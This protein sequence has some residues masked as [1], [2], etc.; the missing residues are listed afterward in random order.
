MTRLF[1][2]RSAASLVLSLTVVSASVAVA[3]GIEEPRIPIRTALDEIHTFG[4]TYTDAANAHQM[5][6]V[7]ALYAEDGVLIG[8]D[9]N[10][11]VGREAIQKALTDN[12]E[13]EV[14]FHPDSA[15]VFGHTAWQ[16]GTMTTQMA[17]GTSH[18]SRYL[19]VLRRGLTEWKIASVAI[20]P[21]GAAKGE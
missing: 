11:V 3:Q 14:T 4:S 21:M 15:H 2:W 13:G 7:A 1:R 5:A 8:P 6:A 10:M 16:T 20:V 19:V 12:G 17:D 9:G 18:M